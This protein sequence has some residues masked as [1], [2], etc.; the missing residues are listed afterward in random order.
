MTGQPPLAASCRGKCFV[1]LTPPGQLIQQ[2]MCRVRR[3]S[4]FSAM[5]VQPVPTCTGVALDIDALRN[6]ANDYSASF[7]E[8]STPTLGRRDSW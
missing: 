8:V 6:D 3:M 2:N 7:G 1:G 5:Q 4:S